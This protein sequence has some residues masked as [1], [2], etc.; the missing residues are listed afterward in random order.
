MSGEQIL[1]VED[2]RTI[3]GAIRTRLRGLGYDV[4]GVAAT[5]KEAVSKAEELLPD[6]ILMDIKLGDGI[7][8]I[9]A[10]L[11][12]RDTLQ[13]PV[14]YVSAYADQEILARARATE[15][16]GFINKPFTTKDLLTTIDLALHTHREAATSPSS[17][18]NATDAEGVV[19]TDM[20][21]LITFANLAAEQ[22]TGYL[23]R[24][25]MR[26]PIDEF[27]AQ[28]YDI[29][30][31]RAEQYVEDTRTSGREV[32]LQRP[33]SGTA[34][35]SFF[36]TLSPLHD[37]NGEFF[38]VALKLPA[39]MEASASAA[40]AS[41][42]DALAA[43]VEPLSMGVAIL[44]RDRS[45]SY[46]NARAKAIIAQRGGVNI[47]HGV[48]RLHDPES[49]TRFQKLVTNVLDHPTP[50]SARLFQLSGKDGSSARLDAA[51]AAVAGRPG[52]GPAD[53]AVVYLLDAGPPSDIPA[54][55]LQ[56]LYGLTATE[57]RL[58]SLMLRGDTLDGCAKQLNMA[59]NTARTHL[60]HIFRKTGTNR[61]I[62][63]VQH[64]KNGPAGL[65]LHFD[66][67][68]V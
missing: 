34:G 28:I 26:R 38:G 37:S 49:D 62:E 61:Q 3:A 12:I 42:I 32:T 58:V 53:S 20:A 15:P 23:R 65:A 30:R 19:T 59:V 5:G 43:V 47:E 56:D 40:S 54:E 66:I 55:V 7:D 63:L 46:M 21:G 50:G 33:D 11:Q 2:Q 60:K 68:E 9:E 18:A 44:G 10:A 16:A 41:R 8:G 29:S 25:L 57:A 13:I 64:I 39:P 1:I 45:I 52:A 31:E 51:V 48:F 6:L 17:P 36:D 22:I 24:Q 27:I 67:E 14:V 4:A 35:G